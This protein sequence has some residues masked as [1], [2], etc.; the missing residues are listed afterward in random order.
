[1][2]LRRARLAALQRVAFAIPFVLLSVAPCGAANEST[3]DNNVS[4]ISPVE[5][6]SAG[7]APL[8]GV[9]DKS[10]ATP[11][12]KA[13]A[14]LVKQSISKAQIL[15]SPTSAKQGDT[16]KIE[17][18]GMANKGGSIVAYD[19]YVSFNGNKVKLFQDLADSSK[20]VCLI[21]IPVT[22][23]HG[24]YK[25]SCGDTSCEVTVVDGKFPT[26][27]LKLPK[28][29]DNFIASP[30]EKDTIKKAKETLS[31]DRLWKGKFERPVKTG[32]IS[33]VFGIRRIVNGK[34]LKDYFH[35]GTD[36]AAP[37]GTPVYA[38]GAGKVVVAKTGW[39]LHGNTVCLDHGQ[40]VISIYIHMNALHVKEGNLVKSGQKIGQVGS[41]GRASGPHLHFGVYVNNEA[42][43]PMNWFAKSY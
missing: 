12:Q 9:Q 5:D 24:K 14:G 7:H 34:L 32:R 43:N 33:S 16:V 40:G 18:K 2:I 13:Q 31:E 29:K 17:V 3:S 39:R 38:C 36:F 1:M 27:R 6:V 22:I 37:R 19:H 30:G 8:P 42:T 11:N 23:D 26:Q 15:V 41:T 25:I 20:L 28:G 35:S 10:E 4:N 21:G